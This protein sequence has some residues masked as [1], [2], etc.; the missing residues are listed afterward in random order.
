MAS[1]ELGYPCSSHQTQGL[2]M[3][4]SLSPGLGDLTIMLDGAGRPGDNERQMRC[5]K[6]AL[7]DAAERPSL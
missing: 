6:H 7:G 4:L 5:V 2:A 3:Q 1:L